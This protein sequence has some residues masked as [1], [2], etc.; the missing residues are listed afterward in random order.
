MNRF[1]SVTAFVTGGAQGMGAEYVR[2][3]V[4]EG[5]KVAIADLKQDEG[6]ALATKLGDHALFVR[7]DVSDEQ[8]WKDALALVT[9]RLG[10]PTVLINNAGIGTEGT[11]EET[12]VAEWDRDMAVNLRGT[13]LGMKTLV[14]GM[15]AAGGGS[16]VNI[17]ST[18]GLVGSAGIAA[19][20]AS[21]WGVRGLTKAAALELGPAIRVNSVHPGPIRTPLAS[22]MKDSFFSKQPLP[23]MGEPSEVANVVLLLA[24][25]EGSYLTGAEIAVDGG[26]ILSGPPD[27]A[28]DGT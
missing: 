20:T 2:R 24:S 23:R 15:R 10:Q 16:I 13:F 12:T 1:D 28:G 21:K 5:G 19:Y 22:W 3:I 17:S 27:K 7:L 4:A 26:A 25:A 6:E 11:I 14:P 9:E 8:N 18:A